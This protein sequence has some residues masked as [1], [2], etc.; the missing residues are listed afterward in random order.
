MREKWEEVE[1]GKGGEGGVEEEGRVVVGEG[2]G[3]GGGRER[4]KVG[5]K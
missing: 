1:G 2:E 5:E 3:E 4:V